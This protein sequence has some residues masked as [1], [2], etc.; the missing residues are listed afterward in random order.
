MLT[1]STS[2]NSSEIFVQYGG[3]SFRCQGDIVGLSFE[4]SGVEVG[5]IYKDAAMVKPLELNGDPIAA[6]S[7]AFALSL[8]GGPAL[9]F[10]GHRFTGWETYIQ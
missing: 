3:Q 8:G 7:I 4:G 5:R 10:A 2:A 1:T 6:D 9:Q